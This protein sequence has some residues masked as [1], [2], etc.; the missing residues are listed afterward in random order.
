MAA[1][2]DPYI[3]PEGGREGRLQA[4]LDAESD[5]RGHAAVRDGGSECDK[6]LGV[7]VVD[8]DVL[9]LDDVQFFQG[10]GVLWVVDIPYQ[11]YM[12]VLKKIECVDLY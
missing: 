4:D 5:Q 11:I 7:R 10:K 9:Q 8:G 3:D 1:L 6:Y 12:K 2:S